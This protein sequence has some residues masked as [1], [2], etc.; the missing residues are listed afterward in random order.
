[1][2]RMFRKAIA[3]GITAAVAIGSF[4]VASAQDAAYQ[5]EKLNNLH[6]VEAVK[7]IK[8][9]EEVT[10]H[11]CVV[12]KED[13]KNI[14]YSASTGKPASFNVYDMDNMKLLRTYPYHTH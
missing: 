5:S 13:G 10:T 8:P 7:A 12:G 3:V 9:F 4:T 2:N 14:L 6:F 1:M 11:D